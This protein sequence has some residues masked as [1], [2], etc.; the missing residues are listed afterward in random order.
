MLV[1]NKRINMCNNKI[2]PRGRPK[3]KV[4]PVV[5]VPPQVNIDPESDD[6]DDEEL[7]IEKSE[8]DYEYQSGISGDS[9]EEIE[10]GDEIEEEDLEKEVPEVPVP[11]IQPVKQVTISAPKKTRSKL[12]RRA[13]PKPTKADYENLTPIPSD[14]SDDDEI[15]RLVALSN[16][17][18]LERE[19]EEKITTPSTRNK[20]SPSKVFMSSSATKAPRKQLPTIQSSKLTRITPLTKSS[21]TTTDVSEPVITPVPAPSAL[22]TNIQLSTPAKRRGRPPKSTTT[23]AKVSSPEQAE[24]LLSNPKSLGLTTRIIKGDMNVDIHNLLVKENTETVLEFVIRKELTLKLAN[25]PN[26]KIN[27]NAAVTLGFLMMKKLKLGVT[28]SVKIEE[29]IG[30]VTGL[31]QQYG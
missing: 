4:E 2:M 24:A 14:E 26:Y 22:P 21:P 28:Y 6:S 30:Y 10:V 16:K 11:I 20:R 25:I 12:V 3:K 15:E 7:L 5:I 19:Q 18:D 27:A 1:H 8:G 17:L 13:T 9:D 31:L 29:V 23:K